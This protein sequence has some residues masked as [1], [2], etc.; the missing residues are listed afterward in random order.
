MPDAERYDVFLSHNSEDRPLIKRLATCLERAGLRVWLDE[1][2]LIPGKTLQPQLANALN[3]SN[4]VA[5]FIGPSGLGLWQDREI[6]AAYQI[7]GKNDKVIPV[8]LPGAQIPLFE[9]MGLFLSLVVPIDFRGADDLCEHGA[10]QKLV[11]TIREE[12]SRSESEPA[13]R[14]IDTPKKYDRRRRI[15]HLV[16][17][18][19]VIL[20]VTTTGLVIRWKLESDSHAFA[21]E[22]EGYLNGKPGLSKDYHK[23]LRSAV[24]AVDTYQ[25]A[26]AKE[27]LLHVLAPRRH[28]DYMHPHEIE[29][30]NF[31]PDGEYILT[32]SKDKIARI[33]TVV[34]NFEPPFRLFYTPL[35][36]FPPVELAKSAPLIKSALYSKD[37]SLVL[38]INE[39]DTV[40][41]WDARTGLMLPSQIKDNQ[42]LTAAIRPDNRQIVTVGDRQVARVW[43]VMTGQMLFS[44]KH[45]GKV[46]YMEFSPDGQYLLT[47]GD[48]TCL[49][50]TGSYKLLRRL[51]EHNSF[52]TFTSDGKSV[53]TIAPHPDVQPAYAAQDVSSWNVETGAQS[54]T[55]KREREKVFLSRQ[56]GGDIN[57]DGR[58]TLM[59]DNGAAVLVDVDNKVQYEIQEEIY[60]RNM[61]PVINAKFSPDGR[62]LLI[63]LSGR[64]GRSVRLYECDVC[65]SFEKSLIRAKERLGSH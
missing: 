20:A 61:A 28:I 41:V 58:L 56:Y 32:V 24:R 22:A 40:Q 17:W 13:S 25:T 52:A 62:L 47:M 26:R 44:F 45:W 19:V 64:L 59:I 36:Q 2:D 42:V 43:E 60:G 46:Q 16:I 65:G 38:T 37:G 54:S 50:D 48:E 55:D 51:G 23:A 15:L 4:A 63:V 3:N 31:S 33:W 11:A 21:A 34:K 12:T 57:S 7:H 53:I 49:W 6:Q 39:R 8:L 29:S 14:L 1:S 9:G 27:V 35:H 5:V 30:A 18:C 10:F